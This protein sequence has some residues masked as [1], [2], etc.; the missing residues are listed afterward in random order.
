ML[1]LFAAAALLALPEPP[2]SLSNETNSR[3]RAQG[4]AQSQP[5]TRT[6]SCNLSIGNT[7]H[8]GDDCVLRRLAAGREELRGGALRLEIVY[9]T[10]APEEQQVTLNG[11]PGS[12]SPLSGTEGVSGITDD[13]LG[14]NSIAYQ[15]WTRGGG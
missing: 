3:A 11:R 13:Y 15:W 6:V 10:R 4:Q 2:Q 9:R 8:T 12:Q 5:Q 7:L 1:S 14:P